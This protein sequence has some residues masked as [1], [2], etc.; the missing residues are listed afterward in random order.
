MRKPSKTK[1]R[2]HEGQVVMIIPAFPGVCQ[3]A[4]FRCYSIMGQKCIVDFAGKGFQMPLEN[5]RPLTKREAR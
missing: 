4:Q 5:I 1:A 2:F 3:P